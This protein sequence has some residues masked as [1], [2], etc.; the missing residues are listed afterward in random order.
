MI[1]E[2]L[3]IIADEVNVFFRQQ[4]LADDGDVVVL[5]N[6]A[7][8]DSDHES[9]A[10]MANKVVLSLLTI[11]EE[12]TL[13]NMPNKSVVNNRTEYKNEKINLNLYVLF[14]GN[15]TFYKDSLRFVSKVIEFFQSK[16]KYI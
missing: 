6:I 12:A 7:L 3:Q 5:D 16:N 8:A 11:D 1:Y 14:S 13:R 4:G 9:A 10:E 2:T 15:K